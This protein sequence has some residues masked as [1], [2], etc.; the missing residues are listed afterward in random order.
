MTAYYEVRQRESDKKWDM[1]CSSGSTGAYAVGYCG[2][3]GDGG[4]D[5]REEAAACWEKYRLDHTHLDGDNPDVMH[6]C[7]VC[8]AFTT[9]YAHIR[10]PFPNEWALCDEHRTREGLETAIKKLGGPH[11]RGRKR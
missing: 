11:V 1:T 4:H 10:Y 5:T 6:R 9:G 7:C 3:E 2:K 8:D